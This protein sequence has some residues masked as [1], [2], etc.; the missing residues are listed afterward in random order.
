[1]QI[2][3]M[4]DIS[5]APM[6]DVFWARSVFSRCQKLKYANVSCGAVGKHDNYNGNAMGSYFYLC[7][8]LTEIVGLDTW[9]FTGLYKLDITS[10]FRDCKSLETIDTTG[11]NLSG[12]TSMNN[13][14]SNCTSLKTII[15]HENWDLSSTSNMALTFYQ[16]TSLETLDVTNWNCGNGANGVFQ[17]SGLKKVIGIENLVNSRWTNMGSLFRGCPLEELNISNWDTSNV[18]DFQYAFNGNKFTEVVGLE[19]LN[20]D[21]CKYADFMFANCTNLTD[22]SKGVFKSSFETSLDTGQGFT[23]TFSGCTSLKK[24]GR[25]INKGSWKACFQG[26]TSLESIAEIN[27]STT[28]ATTYLIF[29]NCN[30]LTSVN[31][32]G[33]GYRELTG[34]KNNLTWHH[35]DFDHDSMLSLFNCLNP[36]AP[37][38]HGT[39]SSPLGLKA[40]ALARMTDEE[41]SIA[42]NKGWYLTGV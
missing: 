8:E 21:S 2:I 34:G 16:C 10:M 14:F 9:D 30:S 40:S 6:K 37:T 27:T 3:G 31:F 4:A 22:L 7:G 1:M 5:D 15:G 28:Y 39:S 20:M 38:N 13:V 35:P 33:T 23:N 41:I 24:I 32:T 36:N 42:T 11:W 25:V 18:I 19:N 12:I 29:Q 26:C 17:G